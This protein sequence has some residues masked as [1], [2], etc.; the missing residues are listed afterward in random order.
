MSVMF[1]KYKKGQ[2]IVRKLKTDPSIGIVAMYSYYICS[3]IDYITELVDEAVQLYNS[4]VEPTI[5]SACILDT[6]SI[7]FTQSSK[8]ETIFSHTS[9]FNI[10]L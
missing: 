3:C 8:S 2:F 1:P 7:S 5:E 6:L 9:R 10:V 4:D